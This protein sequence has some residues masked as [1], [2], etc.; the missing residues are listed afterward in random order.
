MIINKNG[1]EVIKY[2]LKTG[3]YNKICCPGDIRDLIDTIEVQRQEIELC[4]F[5]LHNHEKDSSEL[6]DCVREILFENDGLQLKLSEMSGTLK[7]ISKVSFE[8]SKGDEKNA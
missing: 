7:A 3:F 6:S 2:A 1:L 4:R 5:Y 8:A